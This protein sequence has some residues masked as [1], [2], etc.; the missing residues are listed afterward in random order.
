MPSE[1]ATSAE[2]GI[3]RTT[4]RRAP[5]TLESE[6][7]IESIATTRRSCWTRGRT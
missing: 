7:V 2:F 3:A 5:A 6:G 4:V 1:A